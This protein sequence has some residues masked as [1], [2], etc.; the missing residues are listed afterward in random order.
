MNSSRWFGKFLRSA[1]E[2]CGA[3]LSVWCITSGAATLHVLAIRPQA[4]CSVW[5]WTYLMDHCVASCIRL[6]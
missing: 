1:K 3:F 2:R 5:D 6:V 4:E